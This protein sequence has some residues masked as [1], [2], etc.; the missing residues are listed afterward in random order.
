MARSLRV[1]FPGAVYQVTSHGQA[2]HNSLLVCLVYPV[3]LVIRS[4]KPDR[5]D[6]R[7]RPNRPEKLERPVSATSVRRRHSVLRSCASQ[8]LPADVFCRS[9]SWGEDF[10]VS[11]FLG[12]GMSYLIICASRGSLGH[13][14]MNHESAT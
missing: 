14:D 5:R 9:R 6:R 8:N 10:F 13:D 4:G 7:D 12:D 2:R 3:S 11:I 1:K